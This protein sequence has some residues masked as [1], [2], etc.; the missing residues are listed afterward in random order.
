MSKDSR[1]RRRGRRGRRDAG[2]IQQ[3]IAERRRLQELEE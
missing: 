1:V 2:E 3:T